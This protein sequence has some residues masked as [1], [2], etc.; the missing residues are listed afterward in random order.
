MRKLA[1]MLPLVSLALAA[2]GSEPE[3]PQT[4]EDIAEQAN[5]LTK[6][7]A[8]QYT[9]TTEM[10]EFEVPGLPPAQADQMKQMFAGLGSQEMTYCLTE[11]QASEG[12]EEA[13]KRMSQGEDGVKCT[14]E[15]FDVSGNTLDAKMSCDSGMGGTSSMT[16]AGTVTEESQDLTMTVA[17]ESAQIPGGKMNM[18]MKMTSRRTGECSETES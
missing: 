10:L 1:L 17:Q 15:N 6:P 8:G 13:I 16:M 7:K 14:F 18:K 2:C 11:E 12:F 3:E 4:A 5:K 9:S